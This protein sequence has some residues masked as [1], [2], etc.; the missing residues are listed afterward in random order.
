MPATGMMLNH[1]DL[2]EHP[3]RFLFGAEGSPRGL[4]PRT[5]LLG[6]RAGRGA[7]PPYRDR[8]EMIMV[9]STI[10]AWV[11]ERAK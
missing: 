3:A 2:F 4:R 6:G 10:R 5:V 8:K 11:V 7:P 1:A 9:G